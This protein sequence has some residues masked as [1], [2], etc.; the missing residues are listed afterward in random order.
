M[1]LNENMQL[2]VVSIMRRLI[3]MKIYIAYTGKDG[4][5]AVSCWL[6]SFRSSST[7]LKQ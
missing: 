4:R 2:N 6:V 1:Q 7:I 5:P 3:I